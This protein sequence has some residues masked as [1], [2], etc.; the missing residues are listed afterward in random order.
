ML[1]WPIYYG[2]LYGPSI[3]VYYEVKRKSVGRRGGLL[4]SFAA[5]SAGGQSV[6]W[7]SGTVGTGRT[8]KRPKQNKPGKHV[9][10][11]GNDSGANE[12]SA[13]LDL[14]GIREARIAR[15]A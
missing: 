10:K 5:K 8:K 7:R 14:N 13:T 2:T 6:D 4:P 12:A 15:L 11:K 9:S 3:A 1:N